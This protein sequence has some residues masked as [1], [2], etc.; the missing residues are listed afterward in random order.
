MRRSIS[1][2]LDSIAMKTLVLACCIVMMVG[3]THPFIKLPNIAGRHWVR[4]P[5]GAELYD[6]ATGQEA[7]S[8]VFAMDGDAQVCLGDLHAG[9]HYFQTD[10]QALAWLAAQYH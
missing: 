8:F 3:C 5:L 4:S 10:A 6:D 2:L 1:L 7:A 9:C